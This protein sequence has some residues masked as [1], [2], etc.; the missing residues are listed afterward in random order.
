MDG[1][2]HSTYQDAESGDFDPERPPCPLSRLGRRGM[3]YTAFGK[4]EII[5]IDEQTYLSVC[6]TLDRIGIP[7]ITYYRWYDL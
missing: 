6:W 5:R 2:A 4:L 7:H 1:F 3:R